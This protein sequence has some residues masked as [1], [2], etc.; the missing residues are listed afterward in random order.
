MPDY[1][2]HSMLSF[3]HAYACGDHF[4]PQIIARKVLDAGL[5]WPSLLHD[6]YLFCKACEQCQ[7]IGNTSHGN[8]MPPQP[9][10]FCEIFDV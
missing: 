5:Y 3:C 4:G 8:E 10:L 2:F 1:E 9:I 7:R 6:A